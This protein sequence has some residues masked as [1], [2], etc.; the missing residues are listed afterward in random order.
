MSRII[1]VLLSET[2][3]IET[4]EK[5]P[6]LPNSGVP[7]NRDLSTGSNFTPQ[8]TQCMDACP[9]VFFIRVVK[10]FAFLD[11]EQN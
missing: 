7:D 11:L 10:I 6:L 8:N 1:T 3:H 9:D 4:F 5:R 2:V